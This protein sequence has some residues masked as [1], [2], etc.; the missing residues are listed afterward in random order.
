MVDAISRQPLEAVLVKTFSTNG[1]TN[2]KWH[3]ALK[4]NADAGT[5]TVPFVGNKPLNVSSNNQQ[6]I[7]IVLQPNVTNL[8]DVVVLQPGNQTKF[9]G[10]VKINL[11]FTLSISFY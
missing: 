2:Q 7:T 8:E 4:A 11:H 5:I 9:A 1:V 10:L 3:L 6:N